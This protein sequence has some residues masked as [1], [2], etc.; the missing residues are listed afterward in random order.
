MSPVYE[1]GEKIY[2]SNKIYLSSVQKQ[3]EVC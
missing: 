1:C 2:L 3:D